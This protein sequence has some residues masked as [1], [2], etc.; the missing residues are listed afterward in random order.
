MYRWYI[1]AIALLVVALTG[2]GQ[3]EIDLTYSKNPEDVIVQ[4]TSTGGYVP[5]AYVSSYIPEFRLYGDGRVVWSVW[6]DGLTLVQQGY[7]TDEEVSA[8]LDWIAGMGFFGMKNQYTAKNAPT[9]LP[10][11]CVRVNIMNEQKTVCEYSGGAPKKWSEVYGHL[12]QGA[13][14]ANYQPFRPTIGWVSGEVITW[15]NPQDTASWP[16]SFAPRPKDMM[17]GVWVEGE[18]LE[19]L[20]QG[21]LEQG[22][23]M[24]FEDGQ[25][26]YGLVLQVPGLMPESPD[27]GE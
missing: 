3:P 15:G 11:D 14:V 12:R 9:D 21:R 17:E 4:A 1:A 2:C 13:D 25:E 18:T 26:H 22:P 8:L 24:I 27:T 5:D 7:L 19:T 6:K 23:W 20:W 10:N 16:E